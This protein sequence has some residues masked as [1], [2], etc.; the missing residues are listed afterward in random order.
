MS[1]TVKILNKSTIPVVAYTDL[2][3]A[4]TWFT[5]PEKDKRKGR[6]DGNVYS[7]F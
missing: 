7:I 5:I 4:L 2:S 3:K 6:I 1:K